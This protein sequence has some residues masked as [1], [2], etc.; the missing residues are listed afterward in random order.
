MNQTKVNL[1]VAERGDIIVDF[2]PSRSAPSS[3]SSI[4]SGRTQRAGPDGT[5]ATGD[6]VLKFI[7]DRNPSVPDASRVLTATTPM[8]ELPPID[9]NEVVVAGAR[10]ILTAPMGC[11]R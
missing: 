3:I 7:V 1:G 6:Q 11:G 4:G 2:S 5:T 10:G 9:L 8:R